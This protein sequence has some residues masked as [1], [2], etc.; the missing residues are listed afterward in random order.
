MTT[1]LLVP[2]LPLEHWPSMDRYA[3]RLAQW[4]PRAAP[5][6]ETALAGR[7]APLTLNDADPPRASDPQGRGVPALRGVGAIRRYVTRYWRY[8]RQVR[9][10]PGDLLHLLDHS[11]GHIVRGPRD[12]PAVVT[13]HDLLPLITVRR[14]ARTFRE[15]LRNAMLARVLDGVRGADAW[16][17]ATEWLRIELAEWLGRDEGLHVIPYGVDEAF[18]EAPTAT[19]EETRAVLEIP[20]SAFVVMHVGSVGARKNIPTVIE[21]VHGLVDAGEEAWLLQ[22]GGRFTGEQTALIDRL[23][24][25]P[26]ARSVGEAAEPLLRACYWAAD[27]L[28]FPSHYEGFGL[29]VLEAMASGLPVVC[30]GAGGLSEVAGDA[31]QVINERESAPYVAA[32]K[33]LAL[34]P[35]LRRDYAARGLERARG[36]RWIETATKTAEVYRQTVTR[37]T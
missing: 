37:K 2:D 27:A 30:S 20:P 16:I 24:L 13:V 29:P 25:R 21:G 10:K 14:G 22:V 8:P 15:R 11:Y 23:G 3:S 36:Y 32:L 31:A 12:R 4:L 19:R 33:R 6:L 34:D 26:R 28:L 35:A 7:I 17:V 9:R 18:F 5:D 1:V